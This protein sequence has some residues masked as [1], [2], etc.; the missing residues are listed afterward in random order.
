MDKFGCE[1]A[2]QRDS[3]S[4]KMTFTSEPNICNN[5]NPSFAGSASPASQHPMDGTP[6]E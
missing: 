6:S 3:Q 5:L 1:I 4:N 2:I